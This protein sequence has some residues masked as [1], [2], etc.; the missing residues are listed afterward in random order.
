MLWKVL[1]AP[2]SLSRRGS[3]GT[4]L[5]GMRREPRDAAGAPRAS[6][7]RRAQCPGGMT[8]KRI[9]GRDTEVGEERPLSLVSMPAPSPQKHTRTGRELHQPPTGTGWG[10]PTWLV[11]HS[12]AGREGSRRGDPTS[13]WSWTAGL[14]PG[15]QVMLPQLWAG[16][17]LRPAPCAGPRL[18]L[19]E[20]IAYLTL[21]PG[22]PSP[23]TPW[24]ARRSII[25][26][27]GVTQRVGPARGGVGR[28][29]VG[30]SAASPQHTDPACPGPGCR[31][32]EANAAAAL[33]TPGKWVLSDP[34]FAGEVPRHREVE[35]QPGHSTGLALPE[36]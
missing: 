34:H 1:T 26:Q 15:P 2:S 16:S 31:R 6:G 33:G 21:G 19:D 17:A 10:Q 9:R 4:R 30:H 22:R 14:H 35:R 3:P 13:A 29:D 20:A 27:E 23:A 36:G 12:T 24:S 8:W 11:A 25:G 28:G 7:D 18:V 5:G 32:H